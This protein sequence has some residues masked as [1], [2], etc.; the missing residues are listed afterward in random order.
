MHKVSTTLVA[1]ALCSALTAHAAAI[2][3][4]DFDRGVADGVGNGWSELESDAVDVSLIQRISGGQQLQIRDNDP[5][6]MASQLGGISTQGYTNIV[7]NYEWAPTNNTEAGDFLWVEW[8]NGP[9]GTWSEIA[10]HELIGPAAAQ[11]AS[12]TV[13]GAEGLDAFEF[14][15]R[16]VVNANNEGATIDN[17]A[18][19]GERPGTSTGTTQAVPEPAGTAL[20]G[21]GLGL[22]GF[23]GR[24]RTTARQ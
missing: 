20:A 11:V 23:F 7:L 18:L 15:F 1:A 24:R 5:R 6:A 17:V 2:F 19:A 16:L 14:R 12:W 8:R 13:A 9:A 3:S 4:D 22:L 21:L 10:Q